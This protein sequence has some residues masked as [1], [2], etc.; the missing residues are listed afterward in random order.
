MSTRHDRSAGVIMPMALRICSSVRSFNEVKFSLFGSRLLCNISVEIEA[1]RH[2][3]K[4]ISRFALRWF[5]VVAGMSASRC[6]QVCRFRDDPATFSREP[7][8]CR[9]L[10]WICGPIEKHPGKRAARVRQSA[11]AAGL[12][13]IAAIRA[14]LRLPAQRSAERAP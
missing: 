10:E 7:G 13:R 6:I 9:S 2:R 12:A 11:S 8:Q 4:Y 14:W 5:F 1:A 3:D